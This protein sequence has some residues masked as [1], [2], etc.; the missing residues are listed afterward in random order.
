ML[1]TGRVSKTAMVWPKHFLFL[2]VTE[3]GWAAS[4]AHRNLSPQRPLENQASTATVSWRLS[5]GGSLKQNEYKRSLEHFALVS[6]LNWFLENYL[7]FSQAR[8]KERKLP[9][10]ILLSLMLSFVFF[11]FLTILLDSLC[12]QVIV[13]LCKLSFGASRVSVCLCVCARVHVCV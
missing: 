4:Q 10:N 5:L 12:I 6:N 9:I 2:I 3:I 11:F 8:I 1:P 7:I 13:F